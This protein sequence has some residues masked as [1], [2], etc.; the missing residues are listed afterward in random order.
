M[1]FLRDKPGVRPRFL[2]DGDGDGWL[3]ILLGDAK[4]MGPLP[5]LELPAVEVGCSLELR[6]RCWVGVDD[7]DLRNPTANL[8]LSTTPRDQRD[9]DLLGPLISSPPSFSTKSQSSSSLRVS[10]TRG[11]RSLSCM[12]D[13]IKRSRA[14]IPDFSRRGRAAG[15][16]GGAAGGARVGAVALAEALTGSMASDAAGAGRL[17]IAAGVSGAGAAVSIDA[18]V[19]A[20]IS[21]GKRMGEGGRGV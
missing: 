9:P 21:T 1:L 8:Y 14:G 16:E 11:K 7:D 5:L 20:G 19:G 2:S 17:L 12:S 18:T 4:G 13:S 10:G 15:F 6:D 3:S